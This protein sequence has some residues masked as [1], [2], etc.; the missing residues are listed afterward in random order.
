MDKTAKWTI[1]IL[2]LQLTISGIVISHLCYRLGFENGKASV[3]DSFKPDVTD[4]TCLVP[5]GCQDDVPKHG[6][7]HK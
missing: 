5:T 4:G 2:S 6:R 7:K 1:I 3:Y